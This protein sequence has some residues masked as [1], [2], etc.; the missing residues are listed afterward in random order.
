MK[1]SI[2]LIVLSLLFYSGKAQNNLPWKGKKTAIVL[3]YDDAL[4]QQLDNALPTLDSLGIKATFYVTAY[5]SSVQKRLDAWRK[6]PMQG[7]ELGNHT[8]FHPC[9][10]DM[11][12]RE[13][14]PADYKLNEYSVQRMIDET[15]MTNLFLQA[16][17]GKTER[18]FAFTCGDMKIKDSAFINGMKKDFIAAR[19]VRNE[20]HQ[21]AEINLYNVD[22]FMVNNHRFS[23]MK[24]WVDEAIARNALLVILFHGVGGGSGLDVSVD[25]HRE[26]L[27]YIKSKEQEAWIAP[28]VD[29]AK[30]IQEKQQ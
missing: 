24:K 4:D 18:T 15:R 9:I 6:L 10:A 13:F 5:A 26:L 17:D 11:P 19:A 25:A 21:L 23:E 7:H 22:C 8:L 1:K 12:G 30:F 28:M 27:Q 20:M 14:V 2:C 3:T 16:L 29:V